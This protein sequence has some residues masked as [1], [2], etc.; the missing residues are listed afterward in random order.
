[1][2][3]F[4]GQIPNK[5]QS[6]N[7]EEN[8]FLKYIAQ[9]NYLNNEEDSNNNNLSRPIPI[10]MPNQSFNIN[11]NDFNNIQASNTSNSSKAIN[12]NS[13][14]NNTENTYNIDE[15]KEMRINPNLLNRFSNIFKGMVKSQKNKTNEREINNSNNP[16]NIN[17]NPLAFNP[18]E[19][20][21]FNQSQKNLMQK[22]NFS[23]NASIPPNQNLQALLQL[24]NI[25]PKN[26][27]N[28]MNEKVQNLI[29]SGI[30]IK[31]T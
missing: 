2:N 27:K 5:N 16:M 30:F 17:N 29:N 1:M 7:F 8:F 10:K 13:N 23:Q 24:A 25:K 31:F 4:Q 20:Q 15:E 18:I 12:N 19:N 6:Q 26:F 21:T 14:N 22:N 3:N 11:Q 9:Q 28:N